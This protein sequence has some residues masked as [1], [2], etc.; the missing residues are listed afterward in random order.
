MS[1]NDTSSTAFASQISSLK[2]MFDCYGDILFLH[3]NSIIS[4]EDKCLLLADYTDQANAYVENFVWVF[5]YELRGCGFESCCSYLNFR[6]CACFE[7]GVSW[8]SGNY[9]VWIHSKMST[10]H[11]NKIQYL[12]MHRIVLLDPIL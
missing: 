2:F 5:N 1:V 11:D 7:Q 9:R 6:Y 12:F 3:N 4:V 10:W 8:H